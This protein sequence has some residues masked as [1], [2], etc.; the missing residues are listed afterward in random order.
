MVG[1]QAAT[2]ELLARR[3]TPTVKLAKPLINQLTTSNSIM[4]PLFQGAALVSPGLE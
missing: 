3:S 4:F 2:G 1:R